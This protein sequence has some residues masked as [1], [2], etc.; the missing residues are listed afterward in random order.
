MAIRM[1]S[2]GGTKKPQSAGVLVIADWHAEHMDFLRLLDLLERQL[3]VFD[4][5]ERPDYA[6]MFDILHYLRHFPDEFHHGRED[7]VFAHLAR[8]YPNMELAFVRL[9]QE[10][11]VIENAGQTLL[12]LLQAALDGAMVSRSAIEAAAATYL[13]YYRNHIGV[14]EREVIPRAA[15]AMTPQDWDAIAAAVPAAADP[16]FGAEAGERYSA[17]RRQIG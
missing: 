13:V 6:L 11:R 16:L 12:D 17:L 2:A 10:H 4:S 15:K 14:E 8:A 5:G 3:K 1:R 9:H 7:A